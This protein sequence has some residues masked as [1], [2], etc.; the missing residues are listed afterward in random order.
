MEREI[1]RVL[2]FSA[3]EI[4]AAIIERLQLKDIP[5]PDGK[6]LK[7]KFSLSDTGASLEWT[8]QHEMNF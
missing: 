5:A 7:V 2:N 8:E 6:S 3:E 1:I 4:Q